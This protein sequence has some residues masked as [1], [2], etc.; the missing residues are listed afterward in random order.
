MRELLGFPKY[1]IDEFGNVF[2]EGKRRKPCLNKALG[3]L[4]INPVVGGK[5]RMMYVHRLVAVAYVE[6]TNPT[7]FNV[8]NHK[9]GNKLNNHFSNLEW[10]NK[11]GN[12]KHAFATGLKINALR[13]LTDRQADDIRHLR[14][15]GSTQQALADMYRISRRAIGSIVNFET[16]VNNYE[17]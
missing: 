1:F 15:K 14:A 3:Y 12:E 11:S 2:R 4:Q 9:D 5:R 13:K 17:S 10:T 8:V 16:Y 6:N 7:E